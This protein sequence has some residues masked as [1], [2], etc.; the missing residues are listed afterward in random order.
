MG[1]MNGGPLVPNSTVENA[2]CSD[3]SRGRGEGRGEKEYAG[4]PKM[5]VYKI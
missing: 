4:P 5:P 2:N 1:L 3:E